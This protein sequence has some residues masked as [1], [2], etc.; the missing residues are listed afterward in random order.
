MSKADRQCIRRG[1]WKVLTAKC[2]APAFTESSERFFD[3]CAVSGETTAWHF[4]VVFWAIVWVSHCQWHRSQSFSVQLEVLLGTAFGSRTDWMVGRVHTHILSQYIDAGQN[5][6]GL[7]WKQSSLPLCAM[8][9]SVI[10]CCLSSLHCLTAC[11]LCG[12]AK[13]IPAF[14]A[15]RHVSVHST[16]DCNISC[17]PKLHSSVNRHLRQCS[18]CVPYILTITA[19]AAW[20]LR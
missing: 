3:F 2:S 20:Q 1:K 8:P 5:E 12:S 19:I 6:W 16:L 7:N 17:V 4:N 13:P 11:F 14:A 9:F 18:Y 10:R 15:P